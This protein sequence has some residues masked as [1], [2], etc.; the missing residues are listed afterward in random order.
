[1]KHLTVNYNHSLQQLIYD[2]KL[3]EGAGDSVYGLEVCKSLHLPDNFLKRAYEIRN[4]YNDQSVLKFT[5]TKYNRDKIRGICEFCKKNIGTETH[6]LEYQKNAI[7]NH[8]DG[9]HKDHA[10]N[11]ASIC[12][13]CHKNI[14]QL[15]LVYE[16]RKTIDGSYH[17]ILKR[18][19]TI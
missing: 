5:T 13:L 10:A 8:I 14:H 1:M 16:K 19:E 17:L 3:K 9:F 18:K 2:R 11:L 7:N 12:E 4:K 6:H 15:G